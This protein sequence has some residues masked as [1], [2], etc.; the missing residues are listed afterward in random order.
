MKPSSSQDTPGAGPKERRH[1]SRKTHSGSIFFA[2]RKRL[3]EGEL[4]NYSQSGLG[5]K[6]P[7][8][9]DEGENLTVAL[10]FEE[11]TPAKRPAKVVW[12]NGKGLGAKFVR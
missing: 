1:F 12:C 5:I 4:L 10:P 11:A 7:E 9:F 8:K 3:F 2:T 6:V